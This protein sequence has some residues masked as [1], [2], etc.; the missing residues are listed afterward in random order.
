M[1]EVLWGGGGGGAKPT[2]GANSSRGAKP[3]KY[4][5]FYSLS[6]FIYATNLCT[7]SGVL[8]PRKM[9]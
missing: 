3:R 6:S 7:Y 4:G 5:I 8:R 9:V 2:R 1:S